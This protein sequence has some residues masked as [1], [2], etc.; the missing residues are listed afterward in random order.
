MK[1]KSS[2]VPFGYEQGGEGNIFPVQSELDLLNEV[3]GYVSARAMSLRTA[4][5]WLHQKTGRSISHMGL[6]K[7]LDKGVYLYERESGSL[8]ARE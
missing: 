3:A 5:E 7:R 2:T 4:A 1:K 6:K 8:L